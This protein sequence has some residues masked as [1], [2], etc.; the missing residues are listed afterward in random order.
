MT[1]I[2]PAID[3]R[4]G[5]VV[6]L[7][8]GDYA[9]QTTYAAD[10]L[11][12]AQQYATDGAAWL[13]LVDLDA[14]RNGGFTLGDLVRAIK[15]STGV[16]VQA[17]GGI[18]SRNDIDAVRA[19][20]V[21]RIVIGTLALNAPEVVQAALTELGP[22]ALTLALDVRADDGGNWHCA[23]HGWTE[24]G[25]PLDAAIERYRAYGLRHVLCT[26]IARDGLLGGYNLA[27]YQYLQ[28]RW[29]ALQVQA[30]GGVRDLDDVQAIA[31]MGVSGAILGRALLE[32]RFSL[33]EALAC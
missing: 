4:E 5:R 12:L 27:L 21:D 7:K 32:G 17:G 29:P 31:T 25:M 6:R 2:I 28:E 1:V 10:P 14:A 8:Q 18:R 13:H 19:A 11:V 20:G 23:S 33:S 24:T 3:V 16:R 30:S 22:E 9:Q 15:A 26:D